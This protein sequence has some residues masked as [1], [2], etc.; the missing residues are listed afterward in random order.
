LSLFF[1]HRSAIRVD[2]KQGRAVFESHALQR[3]SDGPLNNASGPRTSGSSSMP[4]LPRAHAA[5]LLRRDSLG[6]IVFLPGADRRSYIVPDLATEK[7]ILRKLQGIRSAELVA[8]LLFAAALIS[9]LLV[10]DSGA[11]VPKWWFILGF[12]IAMLT[13]ELPSEWARRRL[14]H[15]LMLQDGQRCEP[16][17]LER[18]PGGV[19]LMLAAVAVGLSIYFGK[20][21]PLKA[22]TWLDELPLALHELKALAKVAALIGGIA[23]VLW[24][25][26]GAAKRWVKRTRDPANRATS[27]NET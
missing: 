20:I 4:L 11:S 27:K 22:I 7:R 3:F 12:V 21:W 6:R 14:A 16:S 19:V 13:I 25:G 17:L 8:W 5:S 23:A 15:D 9:A 2:G 1:L 24:G 18:L 10:T 26:L